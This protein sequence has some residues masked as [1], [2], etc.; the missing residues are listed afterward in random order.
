MIGLISIIYLSPPRMREWRRLVNRPSWN[1]TKV[2][3]KYKNKRL[4]QCSWLLP[5]WQI[6]ASG[7][8]I[9]VL[10]TIWELEI[11]PV[12]WKCITGISIHKGLWR[13]LLLSVFLVSQTLVGGMQL[14]YQILERNRNREQSELTTAYSHRQTDNTQIDRQTSRHT[15]KHRQTWKKARME[16]TKR[17]GL[18]RSQCGR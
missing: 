6:S 8:P 18:F 12:E 10:G 5:L 14:F 2:L 7:L 3:F 15:D 13:W 9:H 11:Q 16:S 17:S 4:E 1:I